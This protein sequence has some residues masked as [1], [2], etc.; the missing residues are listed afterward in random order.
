[1]TK[2]TSSK[3]KRPKLKKPV[4]FA[5]VLDELESI[6]TFGKGG[7]KPKWNAPVLR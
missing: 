4:P 7:A 2:K 5:F 6:F 3:S 1:M